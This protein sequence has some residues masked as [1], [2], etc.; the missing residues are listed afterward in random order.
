M[1]LRENILE[2]LLRSIEE[3]FLVEGCWEGGAAANNCLDQYSDIDLILCVDDENI[4]ETF[5]YLEKCIRNI[6]PISKKWRVPEPTWNGHSSCHYKL[7]GAA[8]Y[9]LID[10]TIIKRTKIENS[11]EFERHGDLV[12]YIN[13]QNINISGSANNESFWE[14]SEK[15][16]NMIE[17][18]FPFYK[19]IVTKGILRERPFDTLAFYR[20]LVDFYIDL[21]GMKYRPFRYDFKLRYVSKDFPEKELE[22]IERFS[23]VSG[24]GDMKANLDFLEGY[25]FD[26]ISELKKKPFEKNNDVLYSV[27]TEE[28]WGELASFRNIY[29]FEGFE[30]SKEQFERNFILDPK[31]EISE[32]FKA[33]KNNKVVGYGRCELFDP[34]L[35]KSLY[36][37]NDLPY[38]IYLSGV[39]V[40]EEV[41]GQN[42]GIKL[43]ELRID[44]AKERA[45]RI[46][47]FLQNTNSISVKMHEKLGFINI[48][49]RLKYPSDEK[50]DEN[51]GVL[52]ELKF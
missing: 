16:L 15:R 38:G 42:V 9:F 17:E 6:S 47:C 35:G 19:S 13:K 27:A 18:S 22:N 4:E 25:V 7:E 21:L 43:T 24:L 29:S 20:I 30:A 52:F 28:D 32:I 40:G 12:E 46:Y 45:D 26:L 44:W 36:G 50:E 8:E 34:S 39:L 3:C 2:S 37:L 5:D 33:K 51:T 31:K 48:Q 49:E 23:F 14:R 41:R 1:L 11:F 10:I